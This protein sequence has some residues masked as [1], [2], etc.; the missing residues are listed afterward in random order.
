MGQTLQIGQLGKKLG[1]NP[2]TIRYYEEIGLIPPPKR[3]EAAYAFKKGYRLFT[4]KDIERL[5]FIKQAKLLDMPLAQIKALLHSVDE[6]CCS[7]A[8]PQLKLFLEKKLQEVEMRLRGLR[9]LR[10]FLNTLYQET[11]QAIDDHKGGCA[12]IINDSECVFVGFPA[13]VAKQQKEVKEMNTIHHALE[14]EKKEGKNAV[15]EAPEGACCVPRCPDACDE[16]G[17]EESIIEEGKAGLD[18]VVLLTKEGADRLFHGEDNEISTRDNLIEWQEE[19]WVKVVGRCS[20][21]VWYV[22]QNEIVKIERR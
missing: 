16:L 10:G 6:G 4:Q 3:K 12:P 5:Q 8:R 14:E 20:G 2:K 22:R 7:S 19:G 13:K 15:I 1:L 11:A 17:V 9:D 18:R 21:Q